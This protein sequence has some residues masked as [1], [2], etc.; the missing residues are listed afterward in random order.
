[1]GNN[2]LLPLSRSIIEQN[3]THKMPNKINR[4]MLNFETSKVFDIFTPTSESLHEAE[5]AYARF[6]ASKKSLC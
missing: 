4:I 2:E 6:L 5:K 3:I 1:M